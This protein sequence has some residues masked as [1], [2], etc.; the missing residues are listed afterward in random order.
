MTDNTVIWPARRTVY[1]VT[2]EANGDDYFT[3]KVHQAFAE[4]AKAD[5]GGCLES[6]TASNGI[7]IGVDWSMNSLPDEEDGA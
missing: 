4:Y 1:T 7:T 3:V 5:P 2:H 6:F